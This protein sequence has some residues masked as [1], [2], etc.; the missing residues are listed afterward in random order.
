MSTKEY[1]L[2]LAD[3]EQVLGEEVFGFLG[4]ADN[5]EPYVVPLNYGYVD[6]RLFFHCALQGY[7]L[8]ILRANPRVC[9]T[10]GR[11]AGPVQRHPTGDP[12]HGNFDSVVCFGKARI[13]EELVERQQ[14]LD[15]FNRC[16]LPDAAGISAEDAAK[17][18]TVEIRISRMTCRRDWEG[19]RTYGRH[20]FTELAPER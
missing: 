16:L 14:L 13:I 4:L 19:K 9:F 17:C 10:V 6:G 2:T 5:N 12:C 15:R 1:E 8:D 7:K 11:Q 18:Y 20:D 3:M